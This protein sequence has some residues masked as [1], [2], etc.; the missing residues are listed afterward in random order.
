MPPT[1]LPGLTDGDVTTT[2]SDPVTG[3]DTMELLDVNVGETENGSDGTS[4]GTCEE[5]AMAES[6]QGCEFWAVDLPN[7]WAGSSSEASQ[8]MKRWQLNSAS[9]A[10]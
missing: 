6:N 5:A 10:A 7:A 1:G 9:S 2:G 4:P 8:L 3:D